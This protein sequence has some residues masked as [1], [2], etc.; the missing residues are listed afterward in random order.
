MKNLTILIS[1]SGTNLQRIIDATKSG[2]IENAK[3]NLV[4]ADRACFGLERAEKEGVKNI[5]IKRG[6]DFSQNLENQIP[7]NT[8]FIVLA[9]FLSILSKEFCENYEGK[10][11]NI[12]PSLLPK[13]GGKGMW[14]HH[15]HQAVLDAN[16]KESGAT[17]HFVTYGIDE[18]EIILQKSFPIDEGDTVEILQ[19]KVHVVE[20]EIFPKAINLA[21][22]IY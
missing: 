4:I 22:N 15:V 2:E 6:K 19:K 12:H 21:L 18:G 3:I 16:E 11:I 1:G 5:L 13:F 7:E 10:I 9:G 14:G 8:D 17:V 20:Q